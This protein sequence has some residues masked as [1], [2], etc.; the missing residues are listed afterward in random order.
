MHTRLS[1][2]FKPLKTLLHIVEGSITHS[3]FCRNLAGIL[4]ELCARFL[5]NSCKIPQDPTRS[6]RILQGYK[7][8]EP[9]LVRSCKSVF[10]GMPT[11]SVLWLVAFYC[12]YRQST[13]ASCSVLW[14]PVVYFGYL[15]STVAT[16]IVLWLPVIYFGYL[17]S[18]MAIPIVSFQCSL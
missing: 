9:F 3:W 18:T 12:G 6:R 10:T 13:L 7:K 5:E 16:C 1:T 2:R 14:L 17:Q 11:C 4:H 15:Q 8:K